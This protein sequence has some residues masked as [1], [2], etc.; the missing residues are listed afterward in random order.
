MVVALKSHAKQRRC[1]Q[2]GESINNVFVAEPTLGLVFHP[3]YAAKLGRRFVEDGEEARLLEMW[4]AL[5][6]AMGGQG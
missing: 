1:A 6:A 4:T 2:C 5:V 3:R